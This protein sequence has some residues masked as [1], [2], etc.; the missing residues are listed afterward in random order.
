M[1]YVHVINERNKE[2]QEVQRKLSDIACWSSRVDIIDNNDDNIDG[3]KLLFN[4]VEHTLSLTEA[5]ANI[6][7]IQFIR[8][9]YKA[10][11][12]GE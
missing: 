8:G 5:I 10:S 9:N 7:L 1:D 12:F 6:T 11:P 2:R 3:G 4:L